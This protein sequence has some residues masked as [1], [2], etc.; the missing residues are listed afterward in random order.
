[1]NV[2]VDARD[3][4]PDILA[5]VCSHRCWIRNPKPLRCRL[6]VGLQWILPRPE[7]KS[8]LCCTRHM[9]FRRSWEK[10]MKEA[11]GGWTAQ[12]KEMAASSLKPKLT[13][14]VS[15]LPEET[16]H[17]GRAAQIAA[18]C[19]V[20]S[21]SDR[22][23][24]R[25]MLASL[26][27]DSFLVIVRV[28]ACSLTSRWYFLH[29]F[30]SFLYFAIAPKI[31]AP[32]P[33]TPFPPDCFSQL[34]PPRALSQACKPSL[35]FLCRAPD[36]SSRARF[37]AL[38]LVSANLCELC[39]ILIS[40]RTWPR[41]YLWLMRNTKP[42]IDSQPLCVRVCVHVGVCVC[43]ACTVC[44]AARVWGGWYSLRNFEGGRPVE[45]GG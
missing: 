3:A 42:R 24:K 37:L 7:R 44:A 39:L 10:E 45:C 14:Q 18:V 9:T 15:A 20:E 22:W 30:S 23:G 43:A 38:K 4:T 8:R 17:E 27:H 25:W 36:I 1:M 28:L 32:S 13:R 31:K 16:S 35:C 2:S 34:S 19:S 33:D 40:A 21:F 26:L 6:R 11:D 12:I 5:C 29:L 41:I